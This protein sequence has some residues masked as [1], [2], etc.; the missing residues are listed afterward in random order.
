MTAHTYTSCSQLPQPRHSQCWLTALRWK[1]AKLRVSRPPSSR[2]VFSLSE[3][4]AGGDGGSGVGTGRRVGTCMCRRSATAG[5][6]RPG[7]AGLLALPSPWGQ[8]WWT[9]SLMRRPSTCA[10]LRYGVCTDMSDR[11]LRHITRGGF[12][13]LL[14]LCYRETSLPILMLH[15]LSVNAQ[16][17]RAFSMPHRAIRLVGWT[18]IRE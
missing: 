13:C 6:F 10:V 5:E 17:A 1:K 9:G 14:G 3:I 16:R 11:R 7:C 18:C 2:H 12:A 15:G 4:P 8:M